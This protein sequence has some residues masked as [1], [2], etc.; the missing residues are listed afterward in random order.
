ML[1]EEGTLG[2]REVVEGGFDTGT[3][4]LF[5]SPPC[6]RANFSTRVASGASSLWMASRALESVEK[7]PS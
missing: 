2:G 3:E 4:L 1:V 5:P 7:I 6:L